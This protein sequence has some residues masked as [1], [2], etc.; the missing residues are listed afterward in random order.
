MK[1][2]TIFLIFGVLLI[3]PTIVFGAN[4][5]LA[6]DPVDGETIAGYLIYARE[7]GQRY[8]YNDPED[9][10]KKT[11]VTLK[12]FDEYESY[13]FVVRAVD[14]QGNESG[15]SNEVYWDPSGT[16]PAGDGLPDG[17]S[18]DASGDSATLSS[19]LDDI[20]SDSGSG[21]CFISNLL[22]Q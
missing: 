14:V 12:G 9:R 18:T 3:F 16:H 7:A 20:Y 2:K 17:T 22:G 10:V 15:D 5:T 11:T 1:T 19:D 4:V 8:D 6:W 13:Y 21:S